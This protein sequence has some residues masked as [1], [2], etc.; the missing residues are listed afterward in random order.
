MLIRILIIL[1]LGVFLSNAHALRIVSLSPYLTE[2]I[3]L[4]D[5][6][7]SLVGITT[8]SKELFGIDKEVIGDTLNINIEKIVSLKPDIILATPMNKIERVERIKKLGFRVEYFEI[9]KSFEDCCSNFMRLAEMMNKAEKARIIID[10]SKNKLE[11]L[12]C[13]LRSES[14]KNIFIEVGRKPLITAG[15]DCYLNDLIKH[16]GAYNVASGIRG[17]FFRIAREKVLELDPEY[18]LILSEDHLASSRVWRK[19]NFLTAVKYENLIKV[20]DGIFSRPNP[21]NFVQA[22]YLLSSKINSEILNED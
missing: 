15:R 1:I 14:M 6:E 17:G 16:A 18:I 21:V 22:V 3:L 19:Y 2:A 7:D 20:D 13:K 9:E 8:I 12:V 5:G 10:E 11:D 4:L